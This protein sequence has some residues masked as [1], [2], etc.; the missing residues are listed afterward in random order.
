MEKETQRL[1]SL[2]LYYVEASL[3][4]MQYQASMQ[5]I[6]SFNMDTDGTPCFDSDEELSRYLDTMR[7]YVNELKGVVK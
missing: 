1:L 6:E 3:K 2:A 4:D 5:D 7:D